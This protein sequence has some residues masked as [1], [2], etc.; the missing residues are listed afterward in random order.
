MT[1]IL[2]CVKKLLGI[3]AADT[4][5]DVDVLIY[6]N[7]YIMALQQMGVGPATGFVVV[8]DKQTW[9]DYVGEGAI[10]EAAKSYI[11]L[12]TRLVFDPPTS[13]F[14]IDALVKQLAEI[15]WRLMHQAEWRQ[16]SG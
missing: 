5:F 3:D 16:S 2:A 7:T 14:V 6:I 11:Y 12:K 4:S 15:E 13:S 8:D 10:A 9:A 1:S